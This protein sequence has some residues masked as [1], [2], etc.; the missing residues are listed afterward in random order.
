MPS[1]LGDTFLQKLSENK[2]ALTLFLFSFLLFSA[3]KT[4]EK[5]H[6]Y[7]DY[8]DKSSVLYQTAYAEKLLKNGK[9][10]EALIR[11]EILTKNAGGF[12]EVKA[13]RAKAVTQADSDFSS[14]IE[15]KDWNA[16][17]TLFR[18]LAVIGKTPSGWTEQR[19]FTERALMWKNDGNGILLESA[20]G[21]A[22]LSRMQYFPK[23]TAEMIQGTVTVWIDNGRRIERGIGFS[24]IAIGSGFFI[25]RRGYFITNYHV[26]K[27]EVDPKYNGYSK[28]Y[29]KSPHNPDVKIS[30]KV[31]G[32]D[33]LFDLA[34]VKTEIT[35]DVI[36][37]LGSSKKLDIGSRIYAIGSPA[38]L[39]K[40]LTSGIVSTKYRRLFSMVDILQI[41]AAVNHGNSGGPIVDDKGLVQAV[42][43][44]GLEQQEGL[45]FAIPVEL[46]KNILPDL[47]AGGQVK[48][49]WLGGYG[50]AKKIENKNG[51][52]ISYILPGGPLS[53][54][55]IKEGSIITH[56]NG[57]EVRTIEEIQAILLDIAPNT[58]IKVKGYE[59][60]KDDLYEP[61]EWLVLCM[62]RPQFPGKEICKK[63]TDE[64]VMLPLFGFYLEPSGRKKAY[65]VSAVI[66][67]SFADETGFSPN[68]YIELG[69]KKWEDEEDERV[70]H[71]RI[72][73]KKVKSGYLD[74]FMV[75]SAYLDNPLFF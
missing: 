33:P 71:V 66:P 49:S 3:C 40:T 73:A 65:R 28:L 8:S 11:A 74:S 25:D 6:V 32:W 54:S 14:C 34:L 48:H 57:A 70:V 5:A 24:N 67:G 52:E 39:E 15:K 20:S 2:I 42:V 10:A 43:F 26:I 51:V 13:L 50:R 38:G 30:A 29:I 63:D 61:E 9:T 59:K 36:F 68:D 35:P 27:S 16:A 69:G 60:K 46:L 58:I 19:I 56:V 7:V 23:T 18:N 75:I 22:E 72:Y 17:L 44:A 1:S 45:N 41:D 47:Y 12:E 37:E 21:K 64:R 55:G 62:E 31:I 4:A 53:I